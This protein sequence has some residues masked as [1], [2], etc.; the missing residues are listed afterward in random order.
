MHPFKLSAVREAIPPATAGKL[1]RTP[2]HPMIA[3]FPNRFTRASSPFLPLEA[4]PGWKRWQESGRIP[5][6]SSLNLAIRVGFEQT[7]AMKFPKHNSQIHFPS[8]EE[9]VLQSWRDENTFHK[10]VSER[11]ESRK[12]SF[13]MDLHS[14]QDSP[15]T[16][17]CSREPSKTL[18]PVTGP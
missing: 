14:Q 9:Q 15:I 10:S 18:F 1:Q 13:M 4:T 17:T 6:S 3:I 8:M 5:S 7:P 12:F 2:K 11:P 16:D